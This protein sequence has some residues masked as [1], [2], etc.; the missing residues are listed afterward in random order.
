MTFCG[1][2]TRALT[3]CVLY[4]THICGTCT[5][6]LTFSEFLDEAAVM[7]SLK[8]VMGNFVTTYML[9]CV[10]Y[11]C[12]L[13][14][15]VLYKQAAAMASLKEVID[16]YPQAGQADVDK[17]GFRFFHM[18]F[19]FAFFF[20]PMGRRMS[21]KGALEVWIFYFFLLLILY[22]VASTRQRIAPTMSQET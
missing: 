22:K 12:V 4:R 6:A 21:T 18:V 7:A 10:L 3:E 16:G 1:T 20:L 8:E 17:G 11:K 2:C 14:Q 13:Y 19:F 15:C 9:K 5:R